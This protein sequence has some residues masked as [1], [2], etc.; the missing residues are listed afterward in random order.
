MAC[1]KLVPLRK[2]PSRSPE[3]SVDYYPLEHE[4]PDSGERCPGTKT[5]IT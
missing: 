3:R 5:P 2:G 1:A 4:R